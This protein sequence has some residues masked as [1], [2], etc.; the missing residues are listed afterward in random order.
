MDLPIEE[1]HQIKKELASRMFGREE[2]APSDLKKVTGSTV[3][4][5]KMALEA[6]ENLIKK[7]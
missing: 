2:I 7:L 5:V 4:L 3:D 6:I 1:Q